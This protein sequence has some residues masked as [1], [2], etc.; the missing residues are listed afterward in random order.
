MPARR[1]SASSRIRIRTSRRPPAP[2]RR[3]IPRAKGYSVIFS[4]R[5]AFL[6]VMGAAFWSVLAFAN[7]STVEPPGTPQSFRL[8]NGMQV[9]LIESHRVPALTHMLWYHV[10]AADDYPGRSG[11]AHYNEH[12]M[13]Q[14]TPKI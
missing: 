2:R 6:L 14:G 10:G 11:L 4:R 1:P 3:L 12:M 13:F 8:K 7:E 5:V 9:V